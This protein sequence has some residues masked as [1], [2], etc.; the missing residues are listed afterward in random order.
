MDTERVIDMTEEELIAANLEA[1][2][3][4]PNV[5]GGNGDEEVFDTFVRMTKELGDLP[6]VSEV[7]DALKRDRRGVSDAC[8]RL[9]AA[10]R[11]RRVPSRRSGKMGYLPIVT[12]A[13][14]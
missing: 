10:G 12:G 3:L 14:R 1:L 9:A 2:G 13:A 6:K 4:N 5:L 8:A 7:S 11:L